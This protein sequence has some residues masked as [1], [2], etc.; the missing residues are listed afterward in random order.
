MDKNFYMGFGKTSIIE[1]VGKM[2]VQVGE[3]EYRNTDGQQQKRQ[4]SMT[5]PESP[6]NFSVHG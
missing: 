4:Q 2:Q 6:V 5:P 1:R 3:F